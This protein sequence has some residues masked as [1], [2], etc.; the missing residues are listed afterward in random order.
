[1]WSRHNHLGDDYVI[2]ICCETAWKLERFL[3]YLLFYFKV[4]HI[5]VLLYEGEWGQ[6]CGGRDEG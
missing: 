2:S 5:H 4:N 3:F 1:M 6:V